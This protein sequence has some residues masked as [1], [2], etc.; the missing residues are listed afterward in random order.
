MTALTREAIA[1]ASDLT[2]ERVDVPEWGGYVYIS[3]MTGTDRDAWESDIISIG[4]NGSAKQNL[5]NV[6]AKLLSRTIVDEDG[7]A[8]FPDP[9][10]LGKKSGAVLGRLFVIAQKLNALSNDDVDDLA[11]N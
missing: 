8:I 4:E 1:A 3:G 11:K 2:R 7:V 6:R 9:V 10:D 5:D